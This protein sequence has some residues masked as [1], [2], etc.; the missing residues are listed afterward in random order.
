MISWARRAERASVVDPVANQ[1]LASML[2]QQPVAGHTAVAPLKLLSFNID[3]QFSAGAKGFI[4]AVASKWKHM[5]AIEVETK[6]RRD[7]VLQCIEKAEAV[8]C[9]E[10]WILLL[11]NAQVREAQEKFAEEL[12]KEVIERF[13]YDL[14][15]PMVLQHKESFF[16]ENII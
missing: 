10:L 2:D 6:L 12:K 7:K 1:P 5:V 16:S 13:V 9:T 4:D 8:V 11:T 3:L 14:K 15:Q